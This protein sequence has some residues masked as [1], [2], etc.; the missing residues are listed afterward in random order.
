M[1]PSDSPAAKRVLIVA[2]STPIVLAT[3]AS[4]AA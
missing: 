4:S 3:S 1:A 2:A